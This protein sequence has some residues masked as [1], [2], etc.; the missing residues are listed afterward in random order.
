VAL[1]TVSNPYRSADAS[2]ACSQET[3]ARVDA[4]VQRVIADA[5]DQAKDI[6]QK[7]RVLMDRLAQYLLEKETITGAEFMQILAQEA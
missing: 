6:L 2:L 1:E 3:A 7:D 5:H 4:E